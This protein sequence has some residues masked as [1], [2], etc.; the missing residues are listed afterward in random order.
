MINNDFYDDLG[1]DWYINSTH[2]IALLRAEN[3]LRVPWIA[4][5]IAPESHILDVG[6]GGGFLTNA[7][8]LKGH[9]VFGI[10]LS[11][12]SLEIAKQRDTTKS[13]EYKQANAYQLPYSDNSFDA[14]CATD[15]LEHVEEPQQ[16]IKEASRVLKPKGL[17]F[18]HTFNRTALSYLLV[19][20]GVDWFT[21]NPPK[22]MHIYRLFIRPSELEE[23][24]DNHKL[25]IRSLFGMRPRFSKPLW[26]MVFQRKIPSDFSF[27]T[28]RSL[29]TGYCG[30]ARKKGPLSLLAPS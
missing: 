19:I 3:A 12:K 5:T 14:V 26:K 27:R 15:V 11:E 22:N 20:K 9:K 23:M 29:Q 13:V 7:L 21:P 18:F 10:D 4:N 28:C 30:Y 8:A 1:E 25:Q 6:C 16:L 17:F 2:P 24:C